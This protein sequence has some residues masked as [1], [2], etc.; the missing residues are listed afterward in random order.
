MLSVEQI[1]AARALLDWSQ[2][3]LA[4]HAGLSQT[5]I[6][7][8]ENG[9]NQPNT[10]TLR[11][12]EM[13]FEIGGVEFLGK[14]GVRLSTGEIKV[15]RGRDGFV[16]FMDDVYQA[17]KAAGGEVCLHNAK[18]Q[19]WIKWLGE[20]WWNMHS[21]RMKELEDHVRFK[22]TAEEG[23]KEFISSNFAEYR[24]FPPDL[25]HEDSIYAYGKKLAFVNFTTEEVLIRVLEDDSFAKAFKV[26]FNIAWDKVARIP[27]T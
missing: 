8:I 4:D 6:A 16:Q 15:L 17:S 27:P 13:A 5:G 20:D 24:W 22:I 14:T 26:L 2:T 7:R 12:I 1:R 9:T 11:K 18:P 3:D 10:K 19:N 23:N 21:K 25:F